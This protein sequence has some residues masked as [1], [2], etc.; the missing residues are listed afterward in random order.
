M[1]EIFAIKKQILELIKPTLKDREK[2]KKKLSKIIQKIMKYSKKKN[3][4]LNKVVVAGS[5]A[6]NTS[7]KDNTDFDLFLL[8]DKTI[9][10]D[11][12]V[13][14]NKKIIY[15]C[16]WN[17]RLVESYSEHP[18]VQYQ[19]KKYKIDFVPAYE[20]ADY[21]ERK[22]AVDRTPLH[23][24]YLQE[25]LSDKQRNDV[26]ILKQFLKNNLLYG[27]DQNISGFSGYLVEVL[28]L[29]YKDFENFLIHFPKLKEKS[30]IV[31]EKDGK[32]EYSD[33]L[34]VI[35]PVDPNR[36]VAAALSLKQFERTKKLCKLFSEKPSKEFFFSDPEPNLGNVLV[37]KIKKP[38]KNTDILYGM[39][40][41]TLK[42]ITQSVSEVE[43][44]NSYIDSDLYLVFC[45]SK[46]EQEKVFEVK[47]PSAKDV[48]N[49]KKF[50]EKH[51]IVYERN[52][53]LFAKEENK[54]TNV[55]KII[56]SQVIQYFG[57]FKKIIKIDSSKTILKK[58]ILEAKGFVRL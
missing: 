56:D 23:L 20:I 2:Y 1:E 30:R 17:R 18:Y 38:E 28:I 5:F 54:E 46:L 37:Y 22:T 4:P 40:N 49:G 55:E 13:E 44:I 27:S 48:E 41:R 7:L 14:Y 35:D 34:V 11:K 3:I 21:K 32:K 53:I 16:F 25:N 12:I 6:R 50:K 42:R 15:S 29:Y 57:K 10:L 24:K 19:R 36:N 33:P 45:L 9:E 52:G 26:L 58:K 51:P 47:G 39:V 43:G 8:F 31:L